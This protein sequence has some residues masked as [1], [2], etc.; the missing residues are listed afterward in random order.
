[1][2]LA[3]RATGNRENPVCA[4]CT[5][6]FGPHEEQWTHEGGQD[7]D[8]FHKDCLKKWVATHP[9]CPYDRAPI[10]SNSLF[11]RTEILFKGTKKGIGLLVYGLTM[12]VQ[13][14][15]TRV[16]VIEAIRAAERW[17]FS[18]ALTATGL[19]LAAVAGVGVLRGG[20]SDAKLSTGLFASALVINKLTRQEPTPDLAKEISL[21]YPA[22]LG[23]CSML[24]TPVKSVAGVALVMT[25]HLGVSITKAI[26]ISGEELA[27]PRIMGSL[28]IGVG[29]GIGLPLAS[30]V[31][32]AVEERVHE[33]L[34]YFGLTRRD[35]VMMWALGGVIVLNM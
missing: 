26:E 34:N 18:E 25:A 29:L 13:K 31:A 12:G 22:V 1:M 7:H 32:A 8:P 11:S 21:V 6:G 33:W 5:D 9:T 14:V 23:F 28:G 19:A 3:V 16:G 10:D 35:R 17:D 27:L 15:I 2:S 4:I 30:K 24:E 20:A